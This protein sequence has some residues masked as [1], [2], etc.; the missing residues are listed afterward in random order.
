MAITYI[1]KKEGTQEKKALNATY[2]SIG[3]KPVLASNSL[4]KKDK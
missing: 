4:L 3:A 2:K 1:S